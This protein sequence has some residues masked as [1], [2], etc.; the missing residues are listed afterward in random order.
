[1]LLFYKNVCTFATENRTSAITTAECLV[2]N[3]VLFQVYQSGG[4]WWVAL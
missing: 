2:K 1:M 4:P 3:T